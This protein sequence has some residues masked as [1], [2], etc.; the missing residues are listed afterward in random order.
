VLFRVTAWVAGLPV[1]MAIL[2]QLPEGFSCKP[3]N[4]SIS[5]PKISAIATRIAAVHPKTS[6]RGFPFPV[7]PVQRW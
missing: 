7:S 5:N 6:I 2:R 4:Q 1:K 3:R